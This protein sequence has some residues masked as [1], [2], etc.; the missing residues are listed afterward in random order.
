MIETIIHWFH[1]ML[2]HP[3]SCRMCATLQ[4]QYHHTHLQMHIEQYACE[5]CQQAKP[6]G[7][8]HHLLTNCDPWEEFAV[9]LIDP[10]QASM[11]HDN[12]EFFALTCIDTTTNL[13]K[14]AHIFE[15]SSNHNATYFEHTWL[16][17][18]PKPMQAIHDNGESSQDLLFNSS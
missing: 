8:G 6:S 18:Y 7:P 11:L 1:A 17:W 13:V 9:D 4:A 16:Y 14:I 5:E 2:E 12:V 3:S 15:K 10:W